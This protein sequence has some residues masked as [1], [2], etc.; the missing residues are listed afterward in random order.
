MWTIKFRNGIMQRFK[1]PVRTTAEISADPYGNTPDP[2]NEFARLG[3]E[4][5]AE[6][7]RGGGMHGRSR[8][9]PCAARQIKSPAGGE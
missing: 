9:M 1:F 6:H 4:S 3:H 8:L 7:L 2:V 5:V